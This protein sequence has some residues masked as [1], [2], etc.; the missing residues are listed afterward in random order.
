M[1][2]NPN[3]LP[4]D[5]PLHWAAGDAFQW[6]QWQQEQWSPE[7]LRAARKVLAVS[8]IAAL[9]D[10]DG[11][12]AVLAAYAD[13]PALARAAVW[14]LAKVLYEH[15]DG[16]GLAV[17]WLTPAPGADADA[18]EMRLTNYRARAEAVQFAVALIKLMTVPVDQIGQCHPY[19]YTTNSPTPMPLHTIAIVAMLAELFEGNPLALAKIRN[20]IKG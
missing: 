6:L 9:R 8:E 1:T 2:T 19:C 18:D 3:E 17:A 12:G 14:I 10:A 4:H 13:Q 15:P 20:Q 16:A 5:H 7:D 11:V